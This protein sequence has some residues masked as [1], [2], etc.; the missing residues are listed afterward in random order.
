M[1]HSPVS[2]WTSAGSPSTKPTSTSTLSARKNSNNPLLSSN[3]ISRIPS[4]NSKAMRAI[5]T[6]ASKY[7]QYM[8]A[9]MIFN[10]RWISIDSTDRWWTI[11]INPPNPLIKVAISRMHVQC[12]L[13]KAIRSGTTRWWIWVFI[14]SKAT[15]MFICLSRRARSNPIGPGANLLTI[16][17]KMKSNVM[18]TPPKMFLARTTRQ[19]RLRTM[20]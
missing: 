1:H 2:A 16:A 10:S 4:P 13:R 18:W 17:D 11:K 12:L 14:N 20:I 3:I 7:Y 5:W 15:I 8:K 6:R 9:R 19:A